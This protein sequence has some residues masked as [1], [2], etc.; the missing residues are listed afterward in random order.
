MDQEIAQK[1]DEYGRKLDMIEGLVKRI[2][3]YLLWAF[4]GSVVI[5]IVPLIGLLIA[6]PRFLDTY[7]SSGLQ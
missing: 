7:S 3:A 5:F 1:L 2:H 4:I 6:V